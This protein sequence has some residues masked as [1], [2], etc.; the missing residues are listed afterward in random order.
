[1]KT[2]IYNSFEF[3][4]TLLFVKNTPSWLV[5]RG[6]KSK[7]QRRASHSRCGSEV[8]TSSCL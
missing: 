6:T 8:Y 2:I 7:S 5:P 1:M 4:F 3:L